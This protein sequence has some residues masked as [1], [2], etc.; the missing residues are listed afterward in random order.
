MGGPGDDV[1]HTAPQGFEVGGIV[2]DA[3]HTAATYAAACEWW[4]TELSPGSIC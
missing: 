2:D 3:G 1:E 4:T